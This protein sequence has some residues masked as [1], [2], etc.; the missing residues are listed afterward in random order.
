MRALMLV[1]AL[2]LAS[3]AAGAEVADVPDGASVVL[4]DGTTVRLAGIEPAPAARKTLAALVLGREVAVEPVFTDRHGRRH[5]QLR[6]SDGLWIQG[7]ML[8]RGLARVRT[9]PDDRVLAAEMLALEGEA[10]GAGRGAWPHP[11]W[12]VRTPETAARFVDS[13]QLVEGRVVAAERVRNQVFLN[14]GTDRKTD[15]TV[16]I[17]PAALKLWRA[18]ELDPLALDGSRVRVRGWLRAW[19]GPLIDATHPEQVERLP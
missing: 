11:T 2:L 7:E 9:T 17:G 4:G 12:T 3:P 6:R 13:Y 5:A 19:D 10:R 16:R 15:F 1:A 8:S 18:A 14:F